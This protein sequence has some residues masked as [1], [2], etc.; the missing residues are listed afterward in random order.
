M[1]DI[2]V[3]TA[4]D[5]MMKDRFSHAEILPGEDATV[6]LTEFILERVGTK[7]L[8]DVNNQLGDVSK[9]TELPDTM[10]PAN[11]NPLADPE[12]P[13]TAEIQQEQ[14]QI[15]ADANADGHDDKSGRFVEDNQEAVEPSRRS[16]KRTK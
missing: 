14:E 4:G 15:A 8:I 13:R 10:E 5:F 3:R 7:E 2:T 9:L 1:T 16:G 6:P 12:P 11:E